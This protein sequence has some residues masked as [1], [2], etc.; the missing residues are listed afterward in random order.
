MPY[1]GANSF[2]HFWGAMWI[3]WKTGSCAELRLG[4]AL[5]QAGVDALSTKR[6]GFAQGVCGPLWEAW[7]KG[8]G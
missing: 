6:T 3:V 7:E 4:K 8:E 1:P 5:I 2:A